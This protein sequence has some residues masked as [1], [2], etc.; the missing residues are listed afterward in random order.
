MRKFKIYIP[1]RDE[2]SYMI[3]IFQY[4]YNKYWGDAQVNFLGYARPNFD[5][6][7]NISFISLADRRDPNPR[8]WSNYLIDYF[9]SINDEYFYFSL[10]DLLVIRPVDLELL[11]ICEEMMSPSVGRI[12][13]WNS[14]Q[15]DPGRRGM[16]SHYAFHKGV[17]FVREHPFSPPCVYK[18]SCSNSIW[19]RAW[20]LKTLE[21]DWS[22]FDWETKGNDGRNNDGF[23]VLSP[24]NRWTPSVV[25][26]LSGKTWGNSINVDGMFDVDK[27]R[28]AELLSEMGLSYNLIEYKDANQVIN[29]QGYQPSAYDI[30]NI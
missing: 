3:N 18:I 7:D 10:E 17:Q 9:Q 6:D 23:E 11:D 24:I 4:L 12:D 5:L 16:L 26:S 8:S 27:K 15:F 1:V 13:L 19:N 21:R 25:H 30:S 28:V 29:L 2:T 22:T 14:V 20:F